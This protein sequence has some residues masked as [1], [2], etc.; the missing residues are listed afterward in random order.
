[1]PGYAIPS[2][3]A[4]FRLR[5]RGAGNRWEWQDGA[6]VSPKPGTQGAGEVTNQGLR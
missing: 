2:E 6:T 5:T 3:S 1:M 4:E